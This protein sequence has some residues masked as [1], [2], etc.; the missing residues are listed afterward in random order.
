[1]VLPALSIP[2]IGGLPIRVA[3]KSVAVLHIIHEQSKTFCSL[4][5]NR[6]PFLDLNGP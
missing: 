1:M 4:S 3:V 5:I 6:L 2:K